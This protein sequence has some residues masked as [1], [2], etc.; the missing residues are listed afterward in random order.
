[1]T[2]PNLR[3]PKKRKLRRE[4]FIQGKYSLNKRIYEEKILKPSIS[5]QG[6]KI[7]TLS[8]NGTCISYSVHRLVLSTFIANVN[9]LP[10]INHKDT[11]KL[12]NRLDNLEWCTKAYNILHS[13]HHDKQPNFWTSDN[14][15]KSRE[16]INIENDEIFSSAKKAYIS[17]GFDFSYITFLRKLN[18]TENNINDTKFVFLYDK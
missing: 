16:V 18:N 1:M 14:N 10:E 6:Y 5:P 12:N 4:R 17:L 15:F 3:S 9:N 7:V 2:I 13:W 8:T 11:N